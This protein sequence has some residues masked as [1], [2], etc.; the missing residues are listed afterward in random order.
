MLNLKFAGISDPTAN[1]KQTAVT[2]NTWE[3]MKYFLSPPEI[4]LYYLLS[5]QYSYYTTSNITGPFWIH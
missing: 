5:S 4:S 1:T 3:I 2:R